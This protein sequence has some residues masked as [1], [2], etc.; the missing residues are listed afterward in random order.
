VIKDKGYF[1]KQKFSFEELKLEEKKDFKPVEIQ[2]QNVTVD[3]GEARQVRKDENTQDRID[4][5]SIIAQVRSEYEAKILAAYQQGFKE[6]EKVL[7]AKINDELKEQISRFEQLFKNF[8]DEVGNLGRTIESLIISL[9]VEIAKKIVKK[10]IEKDDNFV[11]NQ[12]KDAIKR[13]I[14]VERIKLRINPED[15]KLIKELKPEL[16][17]IADSTRDIIV[18]SDPSVERGGCII[19]SELGNVDARISTQF[20]LIENSLIET[21][22]QQ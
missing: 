5:E 13:V 21:F 12:V 22:N 6:A 17:Q 18:E 3:V 2:S 8:S 19:E 11:I 14:G 1:E 10:E 20:S 9:A 7:K 15:E 4:V 16:L